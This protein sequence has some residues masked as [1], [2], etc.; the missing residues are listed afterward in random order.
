MPMFKPGATAPRRAI[1]AT[2]LALGLTAATGQALATQEENAMDLTIEHLNPEGM[3][4]NPS[5]SQ[6]VVVSGPARTIYIG[7]QNAVNASG[8]I[9]GKGD[10]AAQTEQV[11]QNLETVLTAAGATLHDIILWRLFVVEGQDLRPGLE[12]TMRHW[13]T[14]HAPPAITSAMVP[15]L[16]NPDFLLEIEAIAVVRA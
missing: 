14:E 13:G 10:L 3:H 2:P 6:A 15:S 1:L 9:V 7:G 5:F 12:V 4:Q 8:E 11:F 16:A